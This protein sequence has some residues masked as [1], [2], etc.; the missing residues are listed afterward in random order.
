MLKQHNILS[1]NFGTLWGNTDVCAEHYIYV[2]VLFLLSILSQAFFVIV[3]FDVSVPGH[4]RE[5]V[6]G[7]NYNYKSF[8]FKLISTL[9]LSGAKY[10]YTWMTMHSA[11]STKDVILA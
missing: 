3:G 2:T 8:I 6:A 11:T 7:I 9:Q 4:R 10:Y 5:V 1:V